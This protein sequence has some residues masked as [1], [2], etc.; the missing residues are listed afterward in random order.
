MNISED[1]AAG[2]SKIISDYAKCDMRD[3]IRYLLHEGHSGT[4][5]HC[6]LVVAYLINVMNR[7]N[8]AK[9]VC[10]FKDRR[11]SLHDAFINLSLG[12]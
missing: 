1:C 8:V 7:Q 3:V 4:G 12:M 6:R 5:I 9:W 11:T 2:S 10:E